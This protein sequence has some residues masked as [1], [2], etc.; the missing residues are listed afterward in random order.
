[1]KNTNLENF[2]NTQIKPC[3]LNSLVRS[4]GVLLAFILSLR[5]EAAQRST[6]I[7]MEAIKQ[8]TKIPKKTVGMKC[9]CWASVLKTVLAITTGMEGAVMKFKGIPRVGISKRNH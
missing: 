3:S 8:T 1:M 7:N 5:S 6:A 4:P 2:M 9:S